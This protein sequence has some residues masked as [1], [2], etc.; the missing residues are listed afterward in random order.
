[1]HN[2]SDDKNDLSFFCKRMRSSCFTHILGRR[3]GRHSRGLVHPRTRVGGGA[4]SEVRW[5]ALARQSTSAW[6]GPEWSEAERSPPGVPS[7]PP[8]LQVGVSSVAGPG[9]LCGR[10]AFLAERATQIGLSVHPVSQVRSILQ[11]SNGK[12]RDLLRKWFGPAT[13]S[14]GTRNESA[15]DPQQPPP[16]P[17]YPKG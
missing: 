3:K 13:E 2:L 4:H 1:M 17:Q 12:C 14:A 5:R 7:L 9:K 16:K 10:S 15:L 8:P 6:E 11:T